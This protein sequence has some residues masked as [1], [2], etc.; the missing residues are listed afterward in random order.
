MIRHWLK[1]IELI[2]ACTSS[3]ET[4]VIHSQALAHHFLDSG[5]G[6]DPT[7]RESVE[8]RDRGVIE[9]GGDMT[10]YLA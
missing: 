2:V 8:V 7:N 5:V 1:L 3:H 4:T 6:P 10:K 9:V